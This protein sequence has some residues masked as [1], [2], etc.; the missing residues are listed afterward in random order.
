MNTVEQ[1]Q[2]ADANRAI[3]TE[4]GCCAPTT[5]CANGVPGVPVRVSGKMHTV[6]ADVK[7]QCGMGIGLALELG[8]G[9]RVTA[10][11]RIAV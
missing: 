8:S 3:C 5:L 9:V 11:A 2:Y 10:R 1:S 4:C 6:T 7:Y